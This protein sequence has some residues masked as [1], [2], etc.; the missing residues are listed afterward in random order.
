MNET[1][2]ARYLRQLQC[3]Y[4]VIKRSNEPFLPTD[5]EEQMRKIVAL[6]EHYKFPRAKLP[7]LFAFQ[8][9]IIFKR[10]EADFKR[11]FDDL[12]GPNVGMTRT[13]L[14]TVAEAEDGFLL[15]RLAALPG[16]QPLQNAELI[17]MELKVQSRGMAQAIAKSPGLL[18]PNTDTLRENIHAL[19]AMF[20]NPEDLKAGFLRYPGV[21]EVPPSLR[22]R[23]FNYLTDEIWEGD[24]DAAELTLS[25][26]L[27][28]VSNNT[29]Y[30]RDIYDGLKNALG[31]DFAKKFAR[32]LPDKLSLDSQK[33]Q[34]AASTLKELGFDPVETVARVRLS[35]CSHVL[36]RM[37]QESLSED[38]A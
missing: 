21:L 29:E 32:R 25:R 7:V 23:S 30:L 3:E 38:F 1:T 2:F 36:Y 12:S 37:N 24:K 26:H 31:E 4:P 11:I 9:S 16:G 34:R 28:L 27:K 35:C 13:Q 6:L 18:E 15:M 17:M 10:K 20:K 5:C 33:L 8:E 14:A 22:V 19:K